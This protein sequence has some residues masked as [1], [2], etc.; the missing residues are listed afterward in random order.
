[1]QVLRV[2]L[3]GHVTR[4]LVATALLAWGAPLGGSPRAAA[5]GLRNTPVVQAVRNVSPSVVNIQGQKSVA[6]AAQGGS[7]EV[8]GMGSGVVIDP[9]G[10][11]LTNLHVVEGVHQINVTLSSGQAY[12]AQLLA[13]DPET[14]LAVIRIRAPQPLPTIELGRADDLMVGESVIAVGN[15]FG[16]ENTVS[17]GI[18]S[19]LHRNVQVNE[20]QQYLDLIQ[21]DASIN[22]GNSGGPLLNID[23][24]MVGLNVAVRAGAQGIG[25]A[26]P[27][28]KALDVATRL[29]SV[30]R[31]E[32]HYHGITPLAIDGPAGPVTI[33]RIDRNSPAAAGGLQQGDELRQIGSTTI[34]RPLDV[35]RALLGRRTGERVPVLVNRDGVDVELDLA[36]VDRNGRGGAVASAPTSAPSPAA[37]QGA[38]QE[39][40]WAT[41]GLI[42][43]DEPASTLQSRGLPLE[44]G[45]RVVAVK[46]G[47]S[48]AAQ[49][50]VAGDIL[51]QIH[52][53]YTTSEQDV[54]YILSRSDSIAKLGAVR[55]DIVRGGERFFGQLALNGDGSARR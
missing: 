11:I 38:F 33:A 16:Y 13:R 39:S 5:S 28:D 20:T 14:D 44:G 34:V 55:F 21:T 40:T 23:G 35:E 10:Y 37:P 43:E 19:A 51:V 4:S 27:V 45:M 48:A 52:R 31:L 1:M 22:P 25:F 54:R 12:I 30:Q 17:A 47:S 32:N 7:R 2:S 24:Q 18:I 46:P 41:F 53:W 8:N 6:D 36:V 50:V 9:R 15:A 42:L 29:I 26:I 49:G 3:C